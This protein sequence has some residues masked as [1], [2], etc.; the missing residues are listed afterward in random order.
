MLRVGGRYDCRSHGASRP[1][2]VPLRCA[3]RGMH[4]FPMQPISR[5]SRIVALVAALVGHAALPAT[6]QTPPPRA[7][8]TPAAVTAKVFED[9]SLAIP[10]F[11]F[12]ESPLAL[13]GPA[14]PGAYL[15]AV[16]R[17][18]IAMGTEDGRA[19]LDLWRE[20]AFMCGW[21][22]GVGCDEG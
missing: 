4:S 6:A 14:R 5:G 1:H 16:G 21:E 17:R 12:G 19:W 2:A 22:C 11:R 3:P 8:G 7:P 15:S 13:S 10:A 20:S 18:A 9:G